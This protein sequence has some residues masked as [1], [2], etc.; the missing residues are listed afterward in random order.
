MIGANNDQLGIMPVYKALNLAKEMNLDLVLVAESANPPV[1]RIMNYGKFLYERNKQGR[2]QK[3][4][5]INQAIKLVLLTAAWLFIFTLLIM[6]VI[7]L[8]PR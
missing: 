5:Q 1:C 2:D 7:A 8:R 6:V 4:K 3:K